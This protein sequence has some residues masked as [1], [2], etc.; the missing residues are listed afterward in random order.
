LENLDQTPGLVTRLSR[1]TSLGLWTVL[2][3][4]KSDRFAQA[5]DSCGVLL[6][7]IGGIRILLLS[8]LGTPGQQMLLARYP[9]LRADIV[10]SGVPTRTEPLADAFLDTIQPQVI[11]IT[12]SEYPANERASRAVRD[13][14]TRRGTPILFSRETGAI[15]FSF[16]D[17]SW[18]LKAK[19]GTISPQSD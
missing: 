4:D 14:L 11:V 15:T 5:D 10:I 9:K 1:E 12:D 7:D 2:H 6:G 8:D 18:R 17:S 3:P 19:D 13:R 16:Q